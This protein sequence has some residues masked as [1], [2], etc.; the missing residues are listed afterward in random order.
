MAEAKVQV[1]FQADQQSL[2]AVEKAFAGKVRLDGVG[3]ELETGV[4]KASQAVKSEVD[5]KLLPKTKRAAQKIGDA[6]TGIEKAGTGLK[7]AWSAVAVKFAAVMAAFYSIKKGFDKIIDMYKA[8][9]GEMV[10]ESQLRAFLKAQNEF[11]E[12]NAVQLNLWTEELMRIQREIEGNTTE[13][14]ENVRQAMM[15]LLQ[16]LEPQQIERAIQNLVSVSSITGQG[17]TQTTQQFVNILNAGQGRM[18]GFAGEFSGNVD[19]IMNQLENIVGDMDWAAAG[20][21][22]EWSNLMTDMKHVWRDLGVAVHEAISPDIKEFR[23]YISNNKDQIKKDIRDLV[24]IVKAMVETVLFLARWAN[25]NRDILKYGPLFGPSIKSIRGVFGGEEDSGPIQQAQRLV[26]VPARKAATA[27]EDLAGAA[28]DAASQEKEKIELTKE[29]MRQMQREAAGPDLY[30]KKLQ[31]QNLAAS[32]DP[33]VAASARQQ[34]K[35]IMEM[36]RRGQ[37]PQ[38]YID[39]AMARGQ[40]LTGAH[41]ASIGRSMFAGQA[42][43]REQQQQFLMANADSS[44]MR[45]MG[46]RAGTGG[47]R[48]A[49]LSGGNV[50]VANPS[51]V[52]I[53]VI[54]HNRNAQST[55]V[56]RKKYPAGTLGYSGASR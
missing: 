1:K 48:G 19:E 49:P 27:L 23:D 11:F 10:H 42:L 28:Q 7:A 55:E 3:R 18:R 6:G 44:A 24:E 17:L 46:V 4:S 43:S 9:V 53:E 13:S 38:S 22:D 32:A 36:E 51:E 54:V 29:Q 12:G 39:S 21:L 20:R 40:Y 2:N 47:L 26:E 33:F 35:P 52:D 14:I 8:G 41:G 5:N 50:S 56:S 34:L 15:M 30:Q 45:E 25:E 37:A 16:R 31:L